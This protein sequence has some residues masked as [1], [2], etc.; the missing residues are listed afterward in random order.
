MHGTYPNKRQATQPSI[1][2]EP[3]YPTRSTRFHFTPVNGGSQR[4]PSKYYVFK[5]LV[6]GSASAPTIWGRYAAFA[7]R[8]T[9]AICGNLGIR[10]QMY[11][12]DPVFVATG[13]LSQAV[14]GLIVA[15]L[16]FS[17]LGLPLAW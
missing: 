4:H 12:D 14:R 3:T 10:M 15:L 2:S 11:V 16:W 6:F 7:G 17:I 9:S 5:V 8:S 13:S 1:C